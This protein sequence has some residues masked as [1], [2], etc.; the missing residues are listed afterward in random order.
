MKDYLRYSFIVILC[1]IVYTAFFTIVRIKEGKKR[2]PL[3]TSAKH[4]TNAELILLPLESHSTDANQWILWAKLMDPSIFF[5][6]D[7]DY[8]FSAIRK[9]SSKQPRKNLLSRNHPFRPAPPHRPYEL[10]DAT[11]AGSIAIEDSILRISVPRIQREEKLPA[12][13]RGGG[14]WRTSH[15]ETIHE[16][17]SLSLLSLTKKIPPFPEGPSILQVFPAISSQ[18]R[19][20]HIRSC[21]NSAFDAQALNHLRQFILKCSKQGRSGKEQIDKLLGYRRFYIHWQLPKKP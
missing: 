12:V 11:S 10:F 8:G 7:E 17:S 13:F 1:V 5:L 19:V 9:R 14:Y 21:G 15:G 6:P 4:S 20:K 16:I 2:I 18:I 3:P